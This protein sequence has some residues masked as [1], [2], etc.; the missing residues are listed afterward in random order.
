MVNELLTNSLKHAFFDGRA[1]EI[2]VALRCEDG[3]CLLEVADN[4]VGL[5]EDMT[6]ENT[7]SLG[8]KLVSVLAQQLGGEVQLHRN[9]GTRFVVSF[10]VSGSEKQ[11]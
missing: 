11:V 1:G 5:P 10:P 8:L 4:G 2:R 3:V 7:M 9:S 6:V